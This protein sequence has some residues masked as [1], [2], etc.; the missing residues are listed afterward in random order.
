M[1]LTCPQCG[2]DKI[3]PNARMV[4]QG[5]YSAGPPQIVVD[6][7]PEA[8]LLKYPVIQNVNAIVCG[9]CGVI[10]LVAEN[11]ALLYQAHIESL[12][13]YQ[14]Y[15]ESLHRSSTDEQMY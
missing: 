9:E 6:Q 2:S 3:I 8:L 1:A 12:Q 10:Q 15:L 11:P 13:R 14:A 4:D 7:H 5:R